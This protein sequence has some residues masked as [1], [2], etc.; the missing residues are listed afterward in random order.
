MKKHLRITGMIIGIIAM[1]LAWIWFGWK[2]V[3]V[4]MLAMTGNNI[5]RSNR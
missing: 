4:I 1:V 3:V 2:L 5:E